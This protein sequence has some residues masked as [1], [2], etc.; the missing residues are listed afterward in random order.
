M[1]KV[2]RETVYATDAVKHGL[3]DR[4]QRSKDR[5]SDA[6]LERHNPRPF[7]FAPIEIPNNGLVQIEIEEKVHV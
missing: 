5:S 3:L 7:Q 2:R 4:L 6:W 1:E